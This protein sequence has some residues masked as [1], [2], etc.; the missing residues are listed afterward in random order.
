[1]SEVYLKTM[2]HAGSARA[3]GGGIFFTGTDWINLVV[4]SLGISDAPVVDSLSGFYNPFWKDMVRRGQSATTIA[5]GILHS[6]DGDAFISFGSEVRYVNGAGAMVRY[7]KTD[8][9]VVLPLLAGLPTDPPSATVTRVRNKAI[10]RFIS[11]CQDATT[12]FE[13]G[14]DFGEFH[15]TLNGIHRPLNSLR[16]KLLSYLSSLEKV[17]RSSKNK[18]YLSKALADTYLEFRFGWLPLADDVASAIV[19]CGQ[20]RTPTVKVRGSGFEVHSPSVADLSLGP[21]MGTGYDN[22]LLPHCNIHTKSEYSMTYIGA[23]RSGADAG[24]RSSAARELQ[25][26]PRNW[27]P[28]AWDLLPYSWIG[29]YFTN[30]G[31][32]ISAMCFCWSDVAWGQK[33][34]RKV[35]RRTFGEVSLLRPDPFAPL[36]GFKRDIFQPYTYPPSNPNQSITSFSR[37][38]LT[39]SDLIPRLQFRIPTSKYPYYNLGALLLSRARR[40]VPFF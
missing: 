12:A 23:V 40:L 31:D 16:D 28:T 22:Q 5:N 8:D 38:P 15:E 9:W 39:S 21:W 6:T 1:M 18:I 20:F 37:T 7:F 25:L 14:Q 17:K 19:K 29:D 34:E 10:R 2:A 3:G 36:S 32:L 24:G 35:T 26:L 4:S 33:T 30:V 11:A 27:L 13:A